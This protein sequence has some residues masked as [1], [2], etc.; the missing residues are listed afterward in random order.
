MEYVD[1]SNVWVTMWFSLKNIFVDYFI[2]LHLKRI[3]KRIW[4]VVFRNLWF[5]H[6]PGRTDS[7]G[8]WCSEEALYHLKEMRW[9]LCGVVLV[10]LE[11]GSVARMSQNEKAHANAASFR[12]VHYFGIAH[13][14]DS[15]FFVLGSFEN[16]RFEESKAFA[17]VRWRSE[18]QTVCIVDVLIC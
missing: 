9:P 11:N 18:N 10:F 14:L 8:S 17:K 1:F 7:D 2:Y 13:D 12:T 15:N 6:V 4:C 16:H 3:F 5:G